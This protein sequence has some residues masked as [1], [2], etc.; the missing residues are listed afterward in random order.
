M[1]NLTIW[2]YAL[3]DHDGIPV[4]SILVPWGAVVLSVQ[5]QSGI[6]TLWVICEPFISQSEWHIVERYTGVHF[7]PDGSHYLGTVQS[8]FSPGI[9]SH[10]FARRGDM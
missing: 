3:T 7:E 1:N 9:V 10:F 5:N 4:R 8:E 6:P 2:K